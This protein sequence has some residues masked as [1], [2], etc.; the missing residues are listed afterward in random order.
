MLTFVIGSHTIDN[1]YMLILLS[2]IITGVSCY[3]IY[4]KMIKDK[5]NI[6]VDDSWKGVNEYTESQNVYGTDAGSGQQV[7][8]YGR[9]ELV[10]L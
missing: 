10:I 9:L 3:F 1:H 4:T 7:D 2:V 8:H 6:M 5:L